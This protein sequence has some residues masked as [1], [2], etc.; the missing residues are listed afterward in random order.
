MKGGVLTPL[1][2]VLFSFGSAILI[3]VLS[4][5]AYNASSS[6]SGRSDSN[7]GASG[8]QPALTTSEL[9]TALDVARQELLD[10]E[11]V[12]KNVSEKLASAEATLLES[13]KGKF[14]VPRDLEGD[15]KKYNGRQMRVKSIKDDQF[16]LF[17]KYG[18]TG[19][20]EAKPII[21]DRDNV[22]LTSNEAVDAYD[23]MVDEFDE[24]SEKLMEAQRKV[25]SFETE[26]NKA[27]KSVVVP[28]VVAETEKPKIHLAVDEPAADSK[29]V[30]GAEADAP[31]A[32][33]A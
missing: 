17:V 1:S 12:H 6:S 22:K 28:V 2:I 25:K 13:L 15:L 7:N 32:V 31:A 4:V 9:Q 29:K 20:S 24:A 11:T 5:Y 30:A 19:P 26:L 8:K 10:S 3:A 23:M 27:T 18:L 33:V 16:E 14:V 21:V